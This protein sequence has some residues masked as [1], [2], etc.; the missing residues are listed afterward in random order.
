[1]HAEYIT[2]CGHESARRHQN[3]ERPLR[4][5]S[6]RRCWIGITARRSRQNGWLGTRVREH[7]MTC[8]CVRVTTSTEVVHRNHRDRRGAS[9]KPR[10]T[11]RGERT[12]I[13]SKRAR[14]KTPNHFVESVITRQMST[15]AASDQMNGNPTRHPK[16][17]NEKEKERER[18]GPEKSR[19]QSGTGY[20]IHRL[21]RTTRFAELQALR[22]ERRG[23][24]VP[25]RSTTSARWFG[26]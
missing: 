8:V 10:R 6:A 17:E 20:P 2:L 3:L 14:A 23:G 13:I 11:P 7:Q 15:P 22:T 18:E 26:R 9:W 24:G 21:T 16:T 5:L 12:S 1:M 19:R 4:E 25:L